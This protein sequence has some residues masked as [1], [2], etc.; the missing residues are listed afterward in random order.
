[1]S[2]EDFLAD[3]GITHAHGYEKVLK[4][5]SQLWQR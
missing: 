1:M 5:F 2:Q 4:T 3:E